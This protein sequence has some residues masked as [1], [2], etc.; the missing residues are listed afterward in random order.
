MVAPT[1]R[2][3][4]DEITRALT[5]RKF[6]GA[7]GVALPSLLAACS[8]PS[9]QASASAADFTITAYQGQDVLGG[10]T[11]SFSKV[12]E[13]GKP[14]ILNFWAGLCPP[15]R[16]EMPGFQRIADQ[17]RNK[18]VFVG[19]DIGPFVGLGAH[20]DARRLLAELGIRYPAAFAVDS[21]P[22]RLY[23]IRAMPTTV[24]LSSK[25][26]IVDTANGMLVE[27]Q[28]G[29]KVERLIASS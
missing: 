25:G 23:Q 15:C 28:M 14:V 5:R 3:M 22:V 2:L 26:K 8:A 4:R 13:N 24:F 12:L 21:T 1:D 7:A 11:V 6:L 9:S 17:V 18:V 27:S 20:E 16:A 29:Q 19:V 10:Q